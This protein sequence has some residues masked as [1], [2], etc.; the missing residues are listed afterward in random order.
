MD[1][2]RISM[3]IVCVVV[4]LMLAIPVQAFALGGAGVL[5]PSIQILPDEY[6]APNEQET[7][8]GTGFT[9]NA[10]AQIDLILPSGT[11]LE[12]VAYASV[13]PTGAFTAMFNAPN[14]NG[15]GYVRATDGVFI[16]T[17]LVHYTGVGSG[18]LSISVPSS[19]Y[20]NL[21][22][23]ITITS[24]TLTK[25]NYIV[26]LTV[27]DPQNTE[28]TKYFVLHSGVVYATWKFLVVGNHIVRAM[29]ED[30]NITD[31]D[32]VN[33]L[34][35]SGGGGV[36]GGGGGGGGGGTQNITWIVQKS[37]SSVLIML[38]DGV[39]YVQSGSITV[40]SPSMNQT[41][42]ALSDG[43][44]T[45]TLTESGTY[46][47][48]F[49]GTDGYT[50][51]KT[52]TYNPSVSLTASVSSTTGR[53]TITVSVDGSAGS[54]SVEIT[55]VADGT[56]D[57]ATLSAGQTTYIPDE[58]GSYAVYY[59]YLGKKYSKQV[60]WSDQPTMD[61]FYASLNQGQVTL[62]GVVIGKYTQ[63]PMEGTTVTLLSSAMQKITTATDENGEF[64]EV[65]DVSGMGAYFSKTTL[66]F[67]AQAG[68]TKKTASVSIEKNFFADYWVVLAFI[69]LIIIF[70]FYRYGFL[71]KA[72]GGKMGVPGGMGKRQP[73]GAKPGKSF[74]NPMGGH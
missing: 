20:A 49:T 19:V 7:V 14:N 24:T 11:T 31:T 58:T 48:R 60:T 54:G 26:D 18:D 62:S 29:V 39:D 37:G 74:M 42:I 69:G 67:T 10:T 47:F 68:S 13:S 61:T 34:K 63:K 38:D 53:I 66:Q 1:A 41:R 51:S 25:K 50:T 65:V 6:F 2:K 17:K 28:T 9:G 46:Q 56:S 15:D 5:T 35:G 40:I 22:T 21:N 73:F 16:V 59:T 72:S 55:K 45:F 30:V 57:T 27:S 64:S 4:G 12:G 36:G 8:K 33:V 3:A 23:T 43:I 32:V 71:H 44:A 70:V 52:Y